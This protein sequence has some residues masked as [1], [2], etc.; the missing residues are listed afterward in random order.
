[1]NWRIARA[2]LQGTSHVTTNAPCQDYNKV[3]QFNDY[4]IIAVADGLGSASKSDVGANIACSAAIDFVAKEL[5]D[6]QLQNGL[7][8]RLKKLLR[9]QNGFVHHLKKLFRRPVSDR[10][11]FKKLL[12]MSVKHA[13]NQIFL[14]AKLENSLE[15]EYACTLVLTIIRNSE[16][17]LV[18][19]GDGAVVGV[20]ASENQETIETISG[21]DNG[22]YANSTTPITSPYYAE[23]VRYACNS[24]DK[25]LQ[26]I[27][28]FTDGIQNL[29]INHQTKQAFSGFFT[30]ILQWFRE[31][32]PD[33]NLDDK[34]MELLDSPRIREKCD[35]DLTLVVCY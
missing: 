15:Q 23:H 34:C 10:V 22:E 31:F 7:V 29:C 26:G 6:I 33:V 20:F 9:I 25:K 2:S 17:H 35:D 30:P 4:V 18:H 16:Y 13:R 11:D 24:S 5:R 27:F 3:L 14:R 21:P 1:M 28:V 8:L 19:V 12:T 32:A